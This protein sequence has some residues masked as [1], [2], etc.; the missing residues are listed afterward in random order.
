MEGEGTPSKQ[1]IFLGWLM[2][3]RLFLVRLPR[4]KGE[5]WSN[6]IKNLLRGSIPF[7]S[8]EVESIIESDGGFGKTEGD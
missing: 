5:A 1:K 6:E 8:G 2:D 4:H 3:S 7:S